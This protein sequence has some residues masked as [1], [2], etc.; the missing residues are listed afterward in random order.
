VT[1]IDTVSPNGGTVPSGCA[2]GSACS[3]TQWSKLEHNV[4]VGEIGDAIAVLVSNKQNPVYKPY[5]IRAAAPAAT[6][7]VI[8]AFGTNE[9]STA[10]TATVTFDSWPSDGFPTVTDFSSLAKSKL[11]SSTA[12][13][14]AATTPTCGTAWTGGTGCQG[15]SDM[16]AFLGSTA[17]TALVGG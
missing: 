15:L 2:A 1:Y 13:T 8:D 4:A 5:A 16:W 11:T 7:M 14:W 17:P 10:G 3:N 12:V 6:A 9:I